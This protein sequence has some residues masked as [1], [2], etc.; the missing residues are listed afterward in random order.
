MGL[1]KAIQGISKGQSKPMQGTTSR[2]EHA[3][4][5]QKDYEKYSTGG[6]CICK[7]SSL[8]ELPIIFCF[9]AQVTVSWNKKAK[10]NQHNKPKTKTIEDS[11]ACL[12]CHLPYIS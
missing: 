12:F 2:Y 4:I 3:T 5:R 8:V 9:F 1:Y 7:L 10:T 11:R 6:R